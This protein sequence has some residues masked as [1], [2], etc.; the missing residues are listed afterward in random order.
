MTA[1][2]DY[3]ASRPAVGQNVGR[4]RVAPGCALYEADSELRRHGASLA[5]QLPGYEG[6]EPAGRVLSRP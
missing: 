6:S 4:K 3:T 5:G 2:A 1:I